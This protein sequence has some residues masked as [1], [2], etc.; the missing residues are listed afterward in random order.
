MTTITELSATLQ[1]LLGATANAL[2]KQTG[3]IRRQRRVTGAGF[4]QTLAQDLRDGLPCQRAD[5][6]AVNQGE[7]RLAHRWWLAPRGQRLAVGG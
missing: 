2:A 7:R 3:F 5:Q 4:A 6:W 1:Q